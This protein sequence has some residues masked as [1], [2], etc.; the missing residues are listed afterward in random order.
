MN[1]GDLIEPYL[2]HRLKTGEIGALTA[3]N[4]RC[5]LRHFAAVL[6]GTPTHDL[7]QRHGRIWSESLDG[8]APH[9]RRRRLSS[10]RGFC[11]WALDE[12]HLSVNPVARLRSPR[13]PRTV[14]RAL[15]TASVTQ[16]LSAC[17][18]ARARLIVTWM[19]QLGLRCVEVAGVE[20]GDV[21]RVS[22]T[23]RVTGKGGH[24]RI[25]P[26]VAEAAD[27]LAAYLAEE[28]PAGAGPLIRSRV[29]P[30]RGLAPSTVSNMVGRWMDDAGIKHRSRD[31]VSAHALRH[32]AATDMLRGGAHL[33]DV[34]AALGHAHLQ[35]TEVYLP[36]VVHGL[37]AAME[38]RRYGAPVRLRRAG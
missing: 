19:V 30:H 36:L 12:G 8:L 25:L 22:G 4:D 27:A 31:G 34:Q 37:A 35:T 15:A 13:T 33:R 5:A 6:D 23:V 18:D 7:D 14:P 3:R 9:T 17:P 29:F 20:L 2:G 11:R 32:T 38:G 16:L 21:D 1:I 10:V 28:P 26:L 24:Q